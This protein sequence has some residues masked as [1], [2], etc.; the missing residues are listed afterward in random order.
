MSVGEAERIQS[1]DVLRGF[2]LLGILLLNILGF[3][4]VSAS[5]SNPGFD[6]IGAREIDKI[7]YALVELFGEGAMRCLF[8][9]LFG[10]GVVLFTTGARGKGG[11][12]HYRRTF[13]LLL[14]GLIDGY[15]LLWN[16]DILVTYAVA[17][18]I[19]FVFR[20][21]SARTLLILAAIL[22]GLISFSYAGMGA[23]LKEGRAVEIAL[24][25]GANPQDLSEM[26]RQLLAA[27]LDIKA[28]YMPPAEK[29]MKELE[30]RRGSYA[31]AFHWN[32]HKN[33]EMLTFVI[34]AIMLWDA[35]AM[36]L[37]GMAFYKLG[38]L[39]AERSGRFYAGLMVGG[40]ALGLG[41]NGYEVSRAFASNFEFFHVMGQFQG[42][43]QFGRLGIAFGYLG[44]IGLFC[45]SRA[46]PWLQSSLA[47][48][49]R[50]ALTNYLMHS[51]ICLFLFTGAGLALVGT[52][53][54]ANLYPIV[55][56]I[57]ILQLIL[58]PLWLRMFQYGPVEWI[59]RLMTYGKAPALF[60]R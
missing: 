22:I 9:I 58:S 18:A 35:L 6:L 13:F 41:V 12:L 8:S 1:L 7:V 28:D 32:I 40:F 31:S 60:R 38:I 52:L 29:V 11:V 49:G 10:A 2:S 21:S 20:K 46:L 34:P 37:I 4:L 48:V 53:P 50:M 56:A 17:G 3:G 43:Y 25:E 15:L 57:W 24:E 44:L 23:G 33:N 59:W 55:F 45:Q 42:T 47:A 30:A 5:Y 16:G 27:W 51:V 26:D 14:F 54:R 36:M 19:L 39:Q